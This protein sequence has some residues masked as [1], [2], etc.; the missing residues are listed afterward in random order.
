MKK[1][2]FYVLL[3]LIFI[4]N[5]C[6]QSKGP[7]YSIQKTVIAEKAMVVSAH[8]LASQVGL[9]IIRQGGNAADA[10][11]AVQ[12]ALAVVYPY[13]GNLGGGGFMVIRNQ[14]GSIATLDFREKA[15]GKAHRDMYLDSLGNAIDSLSRSGHLSVGVPGTVDGIFKIYS[16]YS[17]LK[18]FNKLIEPSIELAEK[19]FAVTKKQAERLNENRASFKRHNTAKIAFVKDKEWKEGDRLVQTELA[20]TLKRIRDN[21]EA[22]FYEGATAAYIVAEMKKG[23]GIITHNDLKDYDAVWRKPLTTD[24]KT[25]HIITM[26]PPSSG[27]IVLTQLLE[28][29]ENYPLKD[30][31]FQ[32]KEAIHFMVEA[33]RRAYADRAQ[34]L[35]DSDFYDVPI[36]ELMDS[37]YLIE[38][39]LDFNPQFAT[40]SDSITAGAIAMLPESNETTHFSI[41]DD[42]G[43]AVSLTTTLNSAYGSKTVVEGAGFFLNNEMDDFSAKPGS[44]NLYGLVGAE[45]NAIQPGK[46]MLSS[47]TP[48]IVLKDE[49]LFLVV[50]SPGGSTIITSVFQ[51]FLNV[52]EFGMTASEA[53]SAKRFHHQW[54][55]DVIQIEENTFDSL[56]IQE[57]ESM[58]HTVK[59]SDLIGRVEAILILP[60]GKLEGAADPRRDDDAE[61][62]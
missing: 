32:S 25:F 22:G 7:L 8:P 54:L 26:P 57:L 61:G 28:M 19:G 40:S 21:G 33:E 36:A 39:M 51:V 58:G 23:G 11:I 38:R 5:G 44:P 6:K 35:G 34:H 53:V 56:K 12:F 55:P 59:V 52:A 1:I 16:K 9:E 27:G 43:N 60:D 17:K 15:P 30:W 20:N 45:A 37:T 41:V 62:W 14:D 24:Y 47:M 42:E 13:A 31:G 18:D 50:G 2:T 3:S 10:A 48:T 49:K 4:L 46:R 29:V